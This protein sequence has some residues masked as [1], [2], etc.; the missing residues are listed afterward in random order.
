MLSV[1]ARIFVTNYPNQPTRGSGLGD[2]I[3]LKNHSASA[4]DLFVRWCLSQGKTPPSLLAAIDRTGISLYPTNHPERNLEGNLSLMDEMIKLS[5]LLSLLP[6]RS[7]QVN[8]CPGG[9]WRKHKTRC[10]RCHQACAC[11]RPSGLLSSLG[12]LYIIHFTGN[13]LY[14]L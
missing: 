3:I 12:K 1:H 10:L 5:Y 2:A 14:R 7:K 6:W 4:R 11:V 13:P 8:C 9:V